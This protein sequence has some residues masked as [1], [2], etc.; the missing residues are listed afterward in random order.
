MRKKGTHLGFFSGVVATTAAALAFASPA[1]ASVTCDRV[2]SPTGSD[3]AAGTV[4]APFKTGQKLA[5]S[6]S[7][8]QTGCFRAGTFSGS[9]SVRVPNVTLTSYPGERATLVG[10]FAVTFQGTGDTV[11]N[12]NIDGRPAI[13]TPQISADNVT[14]SGNDVTNHNTEICFTV[15]GAGYRP[16][17]TVIENNNIHNCGK[18]PAQNGDHGIY[19]DDATGTI[20]RGNWIHNNADWGVHMYPNGDHSLVTGNIIDSNGNG[21]IFAGVG[22]QTSDYNTVEH[23]IITNSQL[24]YNAESYWGS[25]PVGVGN[26]AR[27]NCIKGAADPYYA[28]QNGSGIQSTQVG[29]TASSNL[30]VDPGYENA[31]SGDY[32]IP[33]DSPCAAILAGANVDP[34]MGQVDGDPANPPVQPPS[35]TGSADN[36]TPTSAT[37]KKKRGKKR[38]KKKAHPAEAKARA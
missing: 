26:V 18:L 30:V 28:T 1:G 6:L 17:N 16:Q 34:S 9:I 38:A 19:I 7:S 37:V 3:S 31:M 24:G 36:G 33:S 15:G 10:Y 27:N 4:A 5:S 35:S 14:F 11:K 32:R 13:A 20:V 23:N 21:V 25:G 2:A 12:L 22:G 8:G 29:F